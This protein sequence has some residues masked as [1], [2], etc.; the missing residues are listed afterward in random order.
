MHENL[1]DYSLLASSREAVRTTLL[2]S[3]EASPLAE[4]ADHVCWKA[5]IA[6][7]R[8]LGKTHACRRSS[9]R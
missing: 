3:L 9:R 2:Q 1:P 5:I 8:G 6:L 7:P 4:L